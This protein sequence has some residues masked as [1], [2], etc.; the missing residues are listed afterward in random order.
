MENNQNLRC[1]RCG[2]DMEFSGRQQFQLGEESYFSGIMAVMTADSM[3]MDI[4]TCPDC[5]KMEFFAPQIRKR[6]AAPSTNWTC[7]SCGEYNAGKVRACQN[8]GVT[9]QWSDAQKK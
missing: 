4:Y 2:A 5:G 1:L 9:R 3:K 7:A 8:C 6:S